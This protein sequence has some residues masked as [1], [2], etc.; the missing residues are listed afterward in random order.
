MALCVTIKYGDLVK[1]GDAFVM[2]EKYGSN[3]IKVMIDAPKQ[4]K[5]E[6][7][8]KVLNKYYSITDKEFQKEKD[9]L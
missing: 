1:V 3:Q 9:V 7:I 2:V 5:I 6:R 8:K 4:V